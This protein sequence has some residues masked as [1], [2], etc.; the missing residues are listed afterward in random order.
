MSPSPTASG[1][2]LSRACR[3]GL[4]LPGGGARGAYQ[5]GVLKAVAEM[6][7]RRSASPFSVLSGTSAGAINTVVLAS[8]AHL[9]HVG[10]AELEYVWRNFH[11]AQ[12]FKSDPWTMLGNGMHWLFA[13]LT[14][15][16]G[17][18]NPVSLLDNEPLRNLL[19]KRINFDSIQRSIDKGY[20]DAVAVTAALL[21]AVTL[22]LYHPLALRV[23][24][25]P[26]VM[27][28]DAFLAEHLIE[29]RPPSR[30]PFQLG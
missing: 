20:V 21:A 18:R 15:G 1:R 25:V 2:F 7:P 5:V 30:F 24:E 17:G 12:V 26:F 19:R 27:A 23:L 11:A 10:V 3:I 16:L 14:G 29:F 13:V 22:M 4:V 9:F 28:K 8:R 6:L